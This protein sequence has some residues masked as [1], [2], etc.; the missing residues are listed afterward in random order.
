MALLKKFALAPNLLR[1]WYWLLVLL[2][3]LTVWVLISLAL[4]PL[5]DANGSYVSRPYGYMTGLEDSSLDLLFQLRNARHDQLQGRGLAEPITIVEVDEDSIRE[6]NVRLQ[7]W[8]RNWYGRLIQHASD[9]GANTIGLD[10][11]VSEAGGVTEFDR[12]ADQQLLDAITNAGNVIIA[13]KL[14]AGGSAA[15]V[16]LPEFA[17]AA[18][19][20]GF[21]DLPHESDRFVRT[22]ART[23]GGRRR[24]SASPR[25]SRSSTPSS[26]SSARA[27]T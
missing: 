6:S 10:V 3:T 7:K 1:R 24:S 23:T 26:P 18:S 11:Y 12:A 14:E 19:G 15:I 13:Q 20:V 25:S 21:V 27:S 16:P 9:A 22:A 2:L 4:R 17:E 8:P 5:A